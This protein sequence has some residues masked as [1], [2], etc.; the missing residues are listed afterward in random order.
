METESIP[1]NIIKGKYY[2]TLRLSF[3]CDKISQ[4]LLQNRIATMEAQLENC[5]ETIS[6][7]R[8]ESNLPEQYQQV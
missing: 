6:K 7:L 3:H 5:K 2:K 4:L 1:Y 8:Q